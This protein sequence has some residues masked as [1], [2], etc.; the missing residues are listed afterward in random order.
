MDQ[1]NKTTK[2]N[3]MFSKKNAI[4]FLL[5]GAFLWLIAKRAVFLHL[6]LL[7][8]HL[9]LHVLPET[10]SLWGKNN[11]TSNEEARRGC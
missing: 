4:L 7:T 1:V 11:F 10:V 2:T 5:N 3:Q 8:T 6:S 9:T